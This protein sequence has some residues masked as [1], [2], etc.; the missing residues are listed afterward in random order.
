[1]LL[2]FAWFFLHLRRAFAWNVAVVP[3]TNPEQAS[4]ASRGIASNTPRCYLAWRR[5]LLLIALIPLA[6]SALLST[7]DSSEELNYLNQLGW[8][9]TGVDLLAEYVL[10]VSALTAALLWTR[11]GWSQRVVG[12]AMGSGTFC[13]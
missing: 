1:M 5:S 4:L 3:I 7:L 12:P 2:P 13:H 9:L 6:T 10:P 8:L 11:L